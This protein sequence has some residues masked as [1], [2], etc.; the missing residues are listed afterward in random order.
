MGHETG[1]VPVGRDFVEATEESGGIG[2]NVKK[3]V[4]VHSALRVLSQGSVV[5][6]QVTGRRVS[7][8]GREIG[9]RRVT[10]RD[11]LGRR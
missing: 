1:H 8:E 4:T 3:C 10:A 9:V 2:V 5:P 6:R 7:R 11:S